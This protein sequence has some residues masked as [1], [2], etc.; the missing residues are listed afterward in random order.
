MYWQLGEIIFEKLNSFSDF[1]VKTETEIA[2][3]AL[4]SGKPRLQS[5]GEKAI[6]VS[7]SIHIH[8]VF[9]DPG[10]QYDI[11]EKYRKELAVVS[12]IGGD[13]RVYGEFVIK[14]VDLKL[15]TITPEGKWVEATFDLSLI[16]NYWSDLQKQMDQEAQSNSF[17]TFDKI[18]PK[19]TGLI[20]VQGQNSQIVTDL[21]KTNQQAASSGSL[22]DNAKKLGTE[23][24]GWMDKASEKLTEY[25]ATISGLQTK[26]T[27]ATGLGSSAT[28]LL[29]QISGL[30]G[31]AGGLTTSLNGHDLLTS[32]GLYKDF[33]SLQQAF[34][35]TGAPIAGLVTV[36]K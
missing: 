15:S 30:Q 7:I 23:A 16:E 34:F 4:I 3:H 13:G 28:N 2:E 6:E 22:I 10:Q 12:L 29:N 31:A 14:S 25:Q 8:S 24:N 26:L 5:T 11:L 19:Q 36:R 17:A 27:A 9:A 35:S 20:P 21:Q 33:Q 1:G 32:I 18:P